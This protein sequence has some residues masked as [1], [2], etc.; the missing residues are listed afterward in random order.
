M[1]QVGTQ[2][3]SEFAA[4]GGRVRQQFLVAVALARSG[5]LGKIR[6]VTC[7]IDG[8]F[9]SAEVP[10]AAVPKELNW[11]LWT[12]PAPMNAFLQGGY[13]DLKKRW[14]ATRGHHEFRWWYEYSGGKLTDWGAHYVDIA[15]LGHRHGSECRPV[16]RRGTRRR[17]RCRC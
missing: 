1:F 8:G 14:V 16:T 5:R 15:T 9:A 2:Q 6:R 10:A 11:D 13:A 12:G 7:H 3:R 17:I 4:N